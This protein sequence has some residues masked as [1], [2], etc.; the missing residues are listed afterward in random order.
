MT[1]AS[2]TR[3]TFRPEMGFGDY[4]RKA[5]REYTAY[6]QKEMAAALGVTTQAYSAWEAGRNTPRNLTK[7]AERLER[8]TNIDR[9]WFLGWQTTEQ[10]SS[11]YK[12]LVPPKS[13][14]TN[15][16]DRSA[17]PANRSR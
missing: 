17:G 5:R 3:N 13:R 1:N 12:A 8:I 14:P 15:R 6:G 10:R 4:L 7:I 2:E 16:R 9:S 11:D